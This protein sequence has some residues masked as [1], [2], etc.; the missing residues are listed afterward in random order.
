MPIRVECPR[1]H[2]TA[3]FADNDSGLAVACLACGQHLRVP[4]IPP[5]P[6]PMPMPQPI[7]AAERPLRL[8]PT[9]QSP[10]APA[11][12]VNVPPEARTVSAPVRRPATRAAAHVRPAPAKGKWR[13]YTLLFGLLITG[14][15]GGL[16]VAWFI[17]LSKSATAPLA[18]NE[19]AASSSPPAS[20]ATVAA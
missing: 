16:V 12:P 18:R 7:E 9:P 4:A 20:R 10:S 1:C 11:A 6:R 5:K 13:I 3:Y 8:P 15:L 17:N 2:D 14:T 19:I